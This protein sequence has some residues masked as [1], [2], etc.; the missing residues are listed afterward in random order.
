[1]QKLREFIKEQ[2][3]ISFLII[4]FG[5][6]WSI[7]IPVVF[8]LAKGGW[9]PLLY[10]GGYAPFLAGVIVTRVSGGS[11]GLWRWLKKIFR[12]RISII[13][14]LLGWFVMPI[15]IGLVQHGLYVLFGGRPDFSEIPPLWAYP[16]WVPVAALIAGGN[17]EPGWRGFALPK[18]LEF[19]NPFAG[20]LLLGLI[21][22]VWHVPVFFLPSWG[23]SES[24]FY[25]FLFSVL[26]LS[27]IMTWLYYKSRM[28]IF[29]V[30][31]FHQATNI[32]GSYFP[33]PTAIFP[34]WDDWQ[35][36]RGGIYWL[37][38]VVLLIATRGH[39]GFQGADGSANDAYTSQ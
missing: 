11:S 30:M 21:W 12:F 29:P 18:I 25:M 6:S 1:M 28:S 37:I 9:H 14:Y 19:T 4:V 2:Q 34:G 23:T 39:L 17:E 13:W 8:F 26:G 36:L 10:V 32:I 27:V 16:I 7:W 15:A 35:I 20:S 3:L 24:P 31:L 38:A 33:T 5:I 22:A